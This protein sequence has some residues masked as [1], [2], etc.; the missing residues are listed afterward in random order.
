MEKFTLRNFN[1]EF[2]K[3][4]KADGMYIYSKNKK[5]L[6]TTAGGTSFAV[7]GWNNKEINRSINS[8]L[9][10]YSHLCYK[11]WRDDN[12]EKLSE[13]MLKNAEH[14]LDGVYHA[15]NSGGEA[16][17][18]SMKL[19]FLTH[20]AEGKLKKKWFIG[21]NQSY[22]GIGSDALS[23]AERPGLEIFKSFYSRFRTRVKQN[24]YLYEKKK[25]ESED[26][27]SRRCAKELENKILKLGPD[28]VSGFVG[29]TIMGGLVGDVEPSKNY[30]KY[31]REV[32]D[33]YDVHLILDECYSGLGGSGKIYCCDWDR[34]TPDFIFVAKALT[35]GYVP[36]SAVVTRKK[37]FKKI[38]KKFGKIL[39]TTTNQGHSLGIAAALAAQK[40]I[41][42][43]AV[44][45]NVLDK[46]NYIRSILK[47][48][49]S[50]HEFY[51]DVRGRGLRF[52]FEYTCKN[53]NEFGNEL[54]KR[55]L[56]KNNIF[57]NAKWHR[58]CFT[59]AYII[60]KK[61]CDYLLDCFIK[62]FKVLSNSWI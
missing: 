44:L 49:L 3:V 5:I 26:Q 25:F 9:K 47:Q 43:Q 52:S 60:N 45:N 16:C 2:P 22:H 58:V 55:I 27:Y 59:P 14:K 41:N 40:I 35:A 29:E 7:L 1:K 15:G 13:L 39:H 51:F 23:I 33:K 24:H 11:T 17:E 6:D 4:S 48:E 20:Q 32:C 8:Q 46:G 10:K 62:E 61:Q 31:I 21:R 34:I 12:I 53:K 50:N 28:N 38:I 56:R 42:R 18:A 30:W 36:M 19:S 37:Y 54:S 57:I